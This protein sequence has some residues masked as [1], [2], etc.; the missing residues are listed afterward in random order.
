MSCRRRSRLC[1]H[2]RQRQRCRLG[3]DSTALTAIELS[4]RS[5]TPTHDLVHCGVQL[6]PAV[7]GVGGG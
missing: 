4:R 3:G 6:S 7:G 5:H 1:V 2:T